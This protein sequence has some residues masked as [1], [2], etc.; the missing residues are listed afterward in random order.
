[1]NWAR[2]CVCVC[3]ILLIFL[4]RKTIGYMCAQKVHLQASHETVM[5]TRIISLWIING[6]DLSVQKGA[7]QIIYGQFHIQTDHPLELLWLHPKPGEPAWPW[8]DKVKSTACHPGWERQRAASSSWTVNNTVQSW[9]RTILATGWFDCHVF[10]PPMTLGWLLGLPKKIRGVETT[11]QRKLP[12]IYLVHRRCLLVITVSPS[13]Y[14]HR[15]NQHQS[16]ST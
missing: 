1:M 10:F 14:H 5:S 4:V 12:I 11:N 8:G 9:S 13:I 3:V 2:E 16:L 15:T 7:V 6:H